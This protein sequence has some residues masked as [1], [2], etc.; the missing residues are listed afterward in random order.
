MDG[1]D[2]GGAAPRAAILGGSGTR[3][4]RKAHDG[5]ENGDDL[6]PLA[7]VHGLKAF[8]V[9]GLDGWPM[10]DVGPEDHG[11]AEAPTPLGGVHSEVLH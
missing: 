5:H 10:R 9:H 2:H 4:W 11:Q 8:G 6:Q 7:G 1:D 3:A